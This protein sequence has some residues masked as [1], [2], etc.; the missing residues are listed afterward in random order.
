MRGLGIRGL[1][2]IRIAQINAWIDQ[3]DLERCHAIP[4]RLAIAF[5][6]TASVLQ[7]RNNDL[8]SCQNTQ[9]ESGGRVATPEKGASTWLLLVRLPLTKILEY[10]WPTST[11]LLPQQDLLDPG[12]AETRPNVKFVFAGIIISL[13]CVVNADHVRSFAEMSGLQHQFHLS[14]FK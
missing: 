10:S 2:Q 5:R 13:Q 1:K 14:Y 11:M 9:V 4:F 12:R 7:P 8:V 3:A 6:Y